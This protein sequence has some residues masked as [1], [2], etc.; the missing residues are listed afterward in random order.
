MPPNSPPPYRIKY[1]G[2]R[3]LRELER[4][5]SQYRERVSAAINALADAPRPPGSLPVEGAP[6]GTRRIRVGPYRVIYRVDDD[7]YIVNIGDIVTRGDTTY[8]RN[9]ARFS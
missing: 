3:P 6:H 4:L 2:R 5:P 9:Y 1:A 7:N 8:R